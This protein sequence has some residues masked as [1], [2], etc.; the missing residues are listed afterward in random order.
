MAF[1]ERSWH[2]GP[3]GTE[4]LVRRIGRRLLYFAGLVH[5]TDLQPPFETARSM[6][7][8][9]MEGIERSIVWISICKH[10]HIL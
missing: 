5:I 3:T 4:H 8:D 1:V 2:S 10:L 6:G 9:G 7:A